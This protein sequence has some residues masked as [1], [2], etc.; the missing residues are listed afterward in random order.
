MSLYVKPEILPRV[1]SSSA[2]IET[3]MRF[4]RQ[5]RPTARLRKGEESNRRQARLALK[6]VLVNLFRRGDEYHSDIERGKRPSS[7]DRAK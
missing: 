7:I 4:L 1:D 3:A 2:D 5:P 6:T